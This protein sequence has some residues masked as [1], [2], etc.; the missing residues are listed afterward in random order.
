[1]TRQQ[2]AVCAVKIF[3]ISG[4]FVAYP[5]LFLS[6]GAVCTCPVSLKNKN[7]LVATYY[8]IV[9]LIGS[10]CFGHYYAHH[11]ELA[12]IMFRFTILINTNNT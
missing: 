4:R 3:P 8:F 7:Q 12:T 5:V 1:M 2:S 6:Y 10:T 9:L 11:Q